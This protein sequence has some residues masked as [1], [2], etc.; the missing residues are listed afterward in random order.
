MNK[1]RKPKLLVPNKPP[2]VPEVAE[3]TIII[4]YDENWNP[5][6]VWHSDIALTTVLG[7][8][9]MLAER[10]RYL[11]NMTW[12]Q[13]HQRRVAQGQVTPQE[14]GILEQVKGKMQ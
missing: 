4:Q 9:E 12:M 8:A 3:R 6:I 2:A 13:Q 11:L 7:G 5:M 10:I 1:K 14:R